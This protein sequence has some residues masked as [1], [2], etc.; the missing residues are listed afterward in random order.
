[1]GRLL[2]AANRKNKKV[3]VQLKHLKHFLGILYVLEV[4]FFIYQVCTW[5]YLVYL[6][7]SFFT[8]H[9]LDLVEMCQPL[10]TRSLL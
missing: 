5:L 3:P 10:Q 4:K 6:H 7:S 1:M 2:V 8:C 9:T